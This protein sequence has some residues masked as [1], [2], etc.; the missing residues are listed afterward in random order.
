MKHAKPFKKLRYFLA[1]VLLT[2]ALSVP[3]APQSAEA[4]SWANA[5]GSLAMVSA[6]YS[7]LGK[8]VAYY[9]G[10]GRGEY[11]KQIKDKEGV[12]ADPEANAMLDR[13]MTNLS[14]AIA[15]EDPTIKDNPYHYFVNDN[16][17]FNA[18]CT[19]GHNVSVNIGLFKTLNYNEDEVAFVVGHELGH[20]QRRDPANG[21]K[22]TFPIAL[23]A[24]LAGSQSNYLEAIGTNI[25]A[26]LGSAKLVTLP[27][28][29]RADVS[30]F[31]YATEA[32]YNPGAGSALWQRV[33]EKMG[34]SKETFLGSIFMPN[35]HPNNEARRDRYTKR[36]YEYSGNH[37][38]VDKTTGAISVN[39][40]DLGLAQP[41]GDMSARERSYMV[42]GNLAR[43]YHDLLNTENPQVPQTAVTDNTLYFGG[44]KIMSFAYG[45]SEKNWVEG[46]N[47]AAA[48]DS[49]KKLKKEAE[50]RAE[51]NQELK[52]EQAEM[53]QKN[54][55]RANKKKAEEKPAKA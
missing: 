23:L 28:E 51:E 29:K 31:T 55:D 4:F 37:V 3:A 18:Y 33:I 17:H 12:N 50:K 53:R 24:A 20:G 7:L 44:K 36:M 22:K 45:D 21:V 16:T 5:I 6:Q 2:G 42:A 40:V 46:L 35:D 48:K 39:K 34:T 13:V 38:N 11:M 27:M 1:G 14:G 9:D 32:G 19:L 25:V 52:E 49:P 47:K 54:L 41:G 8:Q 43:M 26:N 15:L 30:G 10:S